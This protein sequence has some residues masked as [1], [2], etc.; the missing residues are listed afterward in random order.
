ME[1]THP[2][3]VPHLVSILTPHI[4]PLLVTMSRSMPG[5]RISNWNFLF[6]MLR[7]LR[8]PIYDP[9][10]RPRCCCGKTHDCWGAHVFGCIEKN[11]T[12]AH[13]LLE[14]DAQ[15]PLVL[16]GTC[17]THNSM[18]CRKNTDLNARSHDENS[19]SAINENSE[20]ASLND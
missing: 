5:H 19:A 16:D 1:D 11:K 8:L 13:H 10:T 4:S 7:K 3:H 20:S 12:M 15:T 17:N 2:E 6:T 9:G 14:R 18:S